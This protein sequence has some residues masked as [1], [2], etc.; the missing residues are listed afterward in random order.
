MTSQMNTAIKNGYYIPLLYPLIQLTT[1]NS[2]LATIVCLK[3]FPANYWYWYQNEYNYLPRGYNWIKQFVR[4][5]DTGHLASAL[6]Y[7]S[8][9][10]IPMAFTT[11]FV[12]TVGYW[13]GKL[14]F[15][16]EDG[17]K[18]NIHDLDPFFVKMYTTF[19]HSVPLLLLL[20]KARTECVP[21]TYD[22]W[23]NSYL[24]LYTWFFC[25]YIPWRFK[26]GDPIYSVLSFDVPIKKICLFIGF[27][28][29]VVCVGHL[30]GYA[31]SKC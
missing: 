4:F 10:Y 23:A 11:H 14:W 1:G 17:D 5:T 20:N 18:R 31:L 7:L 2:F 19:N 27:I 22:Q 12:I 28:H 6:V 25:I 13:G 8:P 30:T 26:T 29:V 3:A 24:W 15:S 9:K 16:L 21:F